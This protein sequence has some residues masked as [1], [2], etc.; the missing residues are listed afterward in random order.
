[1][2]SPAF[3]RAPHPSLHIV[4]TLGGSQLKDMTARA[5]VLPHP[6]ESLIWADRRKGWRSTSRAAMRVFRLIILQIFWCCRLI[7]LP[8]FAGLGTAAAMA[9]STEAA[10][11]VSAPAH[12]ASITAIAFE[13]PS[14][15]ARLPQ[16]GRCST[17]SPLRS[18]PPCGRC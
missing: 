7:I 4:H 10:D 2:H 15:V 14:S 6:I 12:A 1:M 16:C 13:P 11:I 3:A 8:V 9:A 5:L 18:L 17:R